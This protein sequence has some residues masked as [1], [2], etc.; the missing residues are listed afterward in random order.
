MRQ[1]QSLSGILLA[2][3][4]NQRV[5]SDCETFQIAIRNSSSSKGILFDKYTYIIAFINRNDG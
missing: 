3:E 4:I 2:A 1:K 5:M